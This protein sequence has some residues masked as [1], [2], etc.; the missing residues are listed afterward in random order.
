MVVAAPCLPCPRAG[1]QADSCCLSSFFSEIQLS[2][3]I[4]VVQPLVTGFRPQ[5]QEADLKGNDSFH[6]I[7]KGECLAIALWV[8]RG[9]VDIS[10]AILLTE[11]L[12]EVGIEL[13]P[14]VG[15]ES[16]GHPKSRDDVLSY[17]V[18]RVLLGDGGQRL[19]FDPLCEVVRGYYQPP[20]VPWSSVEWTYDVQTP[21][22]E[23]PRAG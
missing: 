15:D 7:G 16:S 17:K 20:F 18:L 14:V 2:G 6:V 1:G 3:Y 13:G 8:R 4:Q 21:L 5:G 11:A 9:G 23:R 12:E 22:S 10:D 19:C